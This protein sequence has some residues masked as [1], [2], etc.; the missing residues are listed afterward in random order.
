MRAERYVP[1]R[2]SEVDNNSNKVSIVGN[3]VDVKENSVILED[4]T[5]KIEI[6]LKESSYDLIR[7]LPGYD[8]K[9]VR[10]YCVLDGDRLMLDVLQLMD[11]I[12]LNLLKTV[13]ELYSKAGV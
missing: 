13:D 5:G 9:T 3:V 7:E 10:A 6:F 2:I 11:G 4:D 8:G 12:D 1:K